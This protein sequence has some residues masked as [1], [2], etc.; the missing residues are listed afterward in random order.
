[1][2]LRVVAKLT[3]APGKAATCFII[4]VTAVIVVVHVVNSIVVDS[5]VFVVTAAAF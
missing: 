3:Q 2:G 5:L 1:M 4:I